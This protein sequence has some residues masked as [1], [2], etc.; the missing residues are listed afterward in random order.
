MIFVTKLL[1]TSYILIDIFKDVN[2]PELL[3]TQG[4]FRPL[5]SN[6]SLSVLFDIFDST[7]VDSK[8][9]LA[10]SILHGATETSFYVVT[11][12]YG[13]VGIKKYKKSFIMAFVANLII[14]S[15]SLIFY[16]FL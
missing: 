12:Y 9:S 4:F 16:Y 3:F 6:A 8:L 2:I 13:T 1:S 15:L 5:S 14:F 7:G 11:V 10:G